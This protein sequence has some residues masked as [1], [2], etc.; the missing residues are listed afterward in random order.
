M[1]AIQLGY[2]STTL[3]SNVTRRETSEGLR[4]SQANGCLVFP[5]RQLRI[6]TNVR[7]VIA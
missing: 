4:R 3:V 5:R 1:S 7:F 6:P 2:S